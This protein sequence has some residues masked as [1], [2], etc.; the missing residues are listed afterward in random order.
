MSSFL[1]GFQGSFNQ[2]ASVGAS[3]ITSGMADARRER[4][5]RE[6]R[7][8]DEEQRAEERRLAAEIRA[9]QEKDHALGLFRGAMSSDNP[10]EVKAVALQFNKLASADPVQWGDFSTELT[11]R[12]ADTTRKQASK[13]LLESEQLK[14]M[15]EQQQLKT[16]MLRAEVAGMKQRNDPHQQEIDRSLAIFSKNR[17]APAVAASVL[18]Q[19]PVPFADETRKAALSQA[20]LEHQK[21][22]QGPE[23]FSP[24]GATPTPTETKSTE[25]KPTGAWTWETDKD[26]VTTRTW[27]GSTPPPAEPGTQAPAIT[28]TPHEK[29]AKAYKEILAEI[30]S[31]HY[32]SA[33]SGDDPQE[34]Q[35]EAQEKLD[36]L[37]AIH[38]RRLATLPPGPERQAAKEASKAEYLAAHARFFGNKTEQPPAPQP[39]AAAKP[40]APALLA[41]AEQIKAPLPPKPKEAA[42]KSAPKPEP[43]RKS[44][45]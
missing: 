19:P 24:G 11:T 40:T 22:L 13:Q 1:E 17:D 7:K 10:D 42:P 2:G 6:L 38:A 41:E 37:N 28:F 33:K 34:V 32:E 29:D 27:K 25:A 18:T 39:P 8:Q 23:Y 4:L 43:D 44:V 31:L 35:E 9:K 21:M 3:V 12:V 30:D 5:A 26:G 20:L 14:T 15:A 16:D 36:E 45:V